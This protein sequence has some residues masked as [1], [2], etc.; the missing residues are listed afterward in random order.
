MGAKDCIGKKADAGKVSQDS[1]QAA[2]DLYDEFAA[3]LKASNTPNAERLAEQ[4]TLDALKYQQGVKRK[5]AVA[6]IKAQEG[7]RARLQ[8][9]REKTGDAA[10]ALL[11]FD[12]AG[13]HTGASV[14]QT[15]KSIENKA[16]A[17]M[18][19]SLLR[20]RARFANL[21]KLPTAAREAR[22]ASM[23]DV[24]RHLFGEETGSAQAKSMAEGV[25]NAFEYMRK[26]WNASGGT[27]EKLEKW[28]MPTTHNARLLAAIDE[29]GL[30]ALA[31]AAR[32]ARKAEIWSEYV[33][34]LLDR[35]RM[36]DF[37][38]G[39][40]ISDGNLNRLLKGTYENTVTGG[41]SDVKPAARQGTG[42]FMTGR[43]QSRFLI[44]KDADS[45]LEYQGRFGNEAPF[46][47]IIHHIRS[48]S[49]DI[50]TLRVLGTS[51]DASVRYAEQLIASEHGQG[52][53]E[54]IGNAAARMAGNKFNKAS[55][56][57][58]LYN[59]VSGGL[60]SAGNSTAAILDET[61]R[62]V[63]QSA[64]IAGAALTA[65]SDRAFTWA[66]A[67][68]L[69]LPNGRILGRFLK[70]LNPLSTAD[71]QL[72]ARLGFGAESFL[73]SMIS[74]NRYTGEVFNPG[75]SRTLTDSILRASGLVRLTDA[76][77]TA[78]QIEFLS[79]LTGLRDVAFGDLPDGTLRGFKLHG[80]TKP[81]WDTL[82]TVDL[83][84]DPK[85]G[86][87]FMRPHDLVGDPDS[88]KA[89]P[90]FDRRFDVAAKFSQMIDAEKDFAI[91]SSS[92]RARADV[93]MG[94]RPG[95]AGGILARNAALLKSFPLTL[96]YYH[97]N[98][99]LTA[100]LP[101]MTRAKFAAQIIL[102][103]TVLGALSAQLKNIAAG[104]DPQT[105][106]DPKFWMKAAA[107]GGGAGIA[108]DLIFGDMSRIGSIGDYLLGPALT[109]ELPKAYDLTLGTAKQLAFT[110]TTKGRGKA[111]L[112]FAR[113][114]Q[115][116]R[117]LWYLALAQDR[118]IYDTA[119]QQLDPDYAQSFRRREESA[120]TQ[121]GQEYFSPPGS[122]F[123]PQRGPNLSQAV[124]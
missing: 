93:L 4:K 28:G 17:L 76:G 11:D 86:A 3:E 9:Q 64:L 19:E 8:G 5:A 74:A 1:A 120:M 82:R 49:R 116:G 88:I 2:R 71:Q 58:N 106:E 12:P 14:V 41:L 87:E 72:A 91:P 63:L 20:F 42:G 79:H 18:D 69:G 35:N 56:F 77:R 102:G 97:A 61:N 90:L 30:A 113:L 24:V 104:K 62:N 22:R 105:M 115:P 53:M 13:H 25:G 83:W 108:G 110:G 26:L 66:N 6:Q 29:P 55:R 94:S 111:L 78:F 109:E 60:S 27:I 52:A 36:V 112:D 117:S 118:L 10:M 23:R 119:Q 45:W 32:A 40:P 21:D 67:S 33:T 92:H 39:Q 84:R 51:P 34:P 16:L 46:D 70:E 99:A 95:T 54:G 124:P 31:P 100:D 123:P 75:I 96:M 107:M 114:M 7:I 85:S 50:G 57:T 38:T 37:H 81:D 59:M 121:S 48:F 68:L 43:Q 47:T 101:G 98:R 80:I 122:G 89:G 65:I 73:G 44:F 103:G 15:G